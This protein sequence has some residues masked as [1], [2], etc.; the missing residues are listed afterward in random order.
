MFLKVPQPII[1]IHERYHSITAN[2]PNSSESD[3]ISKQLDAIINVFDKKNPKDVEL[4]RAFLLH[5][6]YNEIRACYAVSFPDRLG[7]FL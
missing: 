3:K 2:L 7:E 5:N 4:L 1:A 6:F